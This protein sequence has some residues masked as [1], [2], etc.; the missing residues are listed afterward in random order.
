MEENLNIFCEKPIVI[1]TNDYLEI[2]NKKKELNFTKLFATGF[3]L[4]YSPIFQKLK[5]VVGKIGKIG[6]VNASD[7]INHTHGA[8]VFVCWRRYEH[9][10][11]GHSVEKVV[12]SLDILNWCIGSKPTKV[13]AFGGNDYWTPENQKEVEDHLLKLDPNCYNNWKDY[14][15][16]N[17][18][19][20]EKTNCD[21]IVSS[22]QYE[23][24][25]KLNLTML[26]YAPN[27]HRTMTF[28]GLHGS[29]EFKWEMGIP[30][31]TLIRDGAGTHGASQRPCD[32]QKWKFGKLGHHGGGDR[33][34]VDS[35]LE[36]VKNETDMAPKIE[37]AFHSNNAC[38]AVTKSLNSGKVEDVVY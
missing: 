21:N 8:H 25:T 11:G 17:P 33:K 34:I 4:R 23:N 32:I 30:E 38:I 28:Y 19:T 24:G 35:L 5:E 18:F 20:A 2:M 9:L 26:T 13:F 36:S 1:N 15:N 12:H 16:L 29:V 27:A 31:I 6:V 10:S 22:I 7:V 14:E 3:C 37:E